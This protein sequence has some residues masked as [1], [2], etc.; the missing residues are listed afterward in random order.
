MTPKYQTWH[1]EQ[2]DETS[3]LWPQRKTLRS[4]EGPEK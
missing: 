2:Q 3:G 1:S 4:N